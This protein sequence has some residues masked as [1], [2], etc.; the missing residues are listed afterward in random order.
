MKKA[1]QNRTFSIIATFLIIGILILA[2]PAKAFIL[3]IEIEDNEKFFGEELNVEAS[4]EVEN[5]ERV[6]VDYF[7]L[8]LKGPKEINCSFLTD[9]SKI[10][11][12]GDI[13]I[14]VLSTAS[15]DQGNLTGS[16]SGVDYNWGYGYGYGHGG[17]KI[18]RY[19][20]TFNSSNLGAGTFETYFIASISTDKIVKRG[21][22]IIIKNP[23]VT[24]DFEI[25]VFSPIDGIYNTPFIKINLSTSKVSENIYA[26]DE[27]S[28]LS[29][30]LDL[31]SNCDSYGYSKLANRFFNN[32][33]HTFTVFATDL[34]GNKIEKKINFIVDDKMPVIINAG[35]RPS[36]N[37]NGSIFYIKYSEDNCKKIIINILGKINK[38][39]SFDCASGK[40]IQESFLLDIGEFDGQSVKAVFLIEDIA[41]NFNK[42][43]TIFLTVDTSPPVLN[44]IDYTITDKRYSS[45]QKIHFRLNITEINFAK[46]MAFNNNPLILNN[47]W[48]TLCTKLNNN[49]CSGYLPLQEGENKISLIVFDRAGNSK[50]E[51]IIVRI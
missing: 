37:N 26:K 20:I 28:G 25:K 6:P 23:P 11:G 39:F 17:N 48:K 49:I 36:K 13:M 33:N 10:S 24:P 1:V 42:P 51:E 4:F 14:T 27:Y 16:N 41:G 47:K 45:S 30:Q 46:V 34:N 40:N 18:F 21:E 44:K 5:S 50:E 3:D 43:R 32:G 2:G 7:I 15:S 31:C 19:N 22:D 35:S 38:S 12:C 8:N 9:G 29:R